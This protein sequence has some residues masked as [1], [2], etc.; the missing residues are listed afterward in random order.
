MGVA[1]YFGI[2]LDKKWRRTVG[3]T[4]FFA[5]LEACSVSRRKELQLIAMSYLNDC[6][7][8]TANDLLESG[9]ILLNLSAMNE[10]VQNHGEAFNLIEK[11][12]HV[13]EAYNLSLV[14]SPNPPFREVYLWNTRPDVM[15]WDVSTAQMRY[16]VGHS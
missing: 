10:A 4:L 11:A 1:K 16:L 9:G 13:Y 2:D 15:L 14:T 8:S 12:I 6:L 5:D 3:V 7:A